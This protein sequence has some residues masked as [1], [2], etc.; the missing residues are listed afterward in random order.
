MAQ[1][2]KESEIESI[3]DDVTKEI[4]EAVEFARQSPYPGAGELTDFLFKQ[5]AAR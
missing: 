2:H 4:K 3:D 1:G 5:D